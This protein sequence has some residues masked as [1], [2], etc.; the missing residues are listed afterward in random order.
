MFE[1]YLFHA[2][3]YSFTFFYSNIVYRLEA[4]KIS[5]QYLL[6]YQGNTT[7][8]TEKAFTIKGCEKEVAK[9]QIL[10]EQKC[11]VLNLPKIDFCTSLQN[12][13][14]QGNKGILLNGI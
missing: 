1:G 6:E 5:T 14:D 7:N 13:S 2:N 9:G 3:T 4:G 10:S 12:G 11:G 8:K